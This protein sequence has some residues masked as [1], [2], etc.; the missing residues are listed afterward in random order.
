MDVSHFGLRVRD[1]DKSKSFYEALGFAEVKR[2]TVPDEMAAGLLGLAPPIGFEAVY[3]QNAGVVLQL[4]TF[5][6]YPA[7]NEAERDMVSAGLTHVSIAVD[8]IAEAQAAVQGAGGTVVADPGGGY[9]CMV[10][11][12]DGQLLELVHS[13]VRPVPRG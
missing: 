12:P 10:R 8:D 5:S 7:P 6:G 2:L 3:L 11:D 4:L 9:A 13:R 1:L